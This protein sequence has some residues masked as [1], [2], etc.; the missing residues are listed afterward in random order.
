M[1]L[2]K[3]L[4]IFLVIFLFA[5][6]TNPSYAIKI[7]LLNS[8]TEA[9]VGTNVV[10]VIT[11]GNTNKILF[12]TGKMTAYKIRPYQGILSI[13]INGQRYKLK[14]N[15]AV[16]KTTEPNGFVFVKKGWYRGVLIVRNCGGF[17]QVVNKVPLEEYIMGVVPSE[18]PSKWNF[19]AHRAQAIAARSYA[20]SNL[21]KRSKRGF[22]LLDTP[23]DQAYRGASAETPQTNQA[24]RSTEGV[25]MTY[26][27]KII[28]AYYHSSSG[29]HTKQSGEVWA[30]N[31]PYLKSVDGY[32][33]GKRKF[34]HGVGM[35]QYGA[36]NL[37]GMGY[38]GFQIL[39]H[40]Y[41]N[42]SFAKVK[43]PNLY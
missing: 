5:I 11:D 26:N 2:I 17:M 41:N 20:L 25:V 27:N 36:N 21:G 33:W 24:V 42:V 35:S 12:K 37:A 22:D 28:T 13:E 40:Y 7:G 4:K 38:G 15:N 1:S 18:M 31:L 39:N 10:G 32:D 29:G 43:N 8:V 14:T 6:C 16:I 3:T 34:G 30:K 23:Q 19:E 9:T